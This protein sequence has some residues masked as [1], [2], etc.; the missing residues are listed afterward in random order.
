VRFA[1]RLTELVLSTTTTTTQSCGRNWGVCSSSLK[2]WTVS[3]SST[4]GSAKR[5]RRASSN[6]SAPFGFSGGCSEW[7]F[8]DCPQHLAFSTAEEEIDGHQGSHVII[9]PID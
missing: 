6:V 5:T 2:T 8:C 4:G 1:E 3:E 9:E 7:L